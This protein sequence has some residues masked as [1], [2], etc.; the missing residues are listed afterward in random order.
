M[1]FV[2]FFLKNLVNGDGPVTL[3][4]VVDWASRSTKSSENFTYF[5]NGVIS[6]IS[7]E[8]KYYKSCNRSILFFSFKK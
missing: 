3:L 5:I 6:Q 4:K 2:F 8:K 1:N 7:L